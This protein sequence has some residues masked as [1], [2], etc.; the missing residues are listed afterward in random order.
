[1]KRFLRKVIGGIMAAI[2]TALA[3]VAFAGY[4]WQFLS[5]AICAMAAIDLLFGN[6]KKDKDTK[7]KG[8]QYA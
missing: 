7:Q 4:W 2:A 1:M 6:D 3:V 8:V 5:A